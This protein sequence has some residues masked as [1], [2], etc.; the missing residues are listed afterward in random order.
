MAPLAVYGLGE[1]ERIIELK[2]N[3]KTRKKLIV[4]VCAYFYG[5]MLKFV[6]VFMLHHIVSR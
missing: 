1:K 3:L 4:I 6:V 5:K 2:K